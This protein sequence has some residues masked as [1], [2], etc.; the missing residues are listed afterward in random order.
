[1]AVK[2]TTCEFTGPGACSLCLVSE[3][4]SSP[5]SITTCMNIATV[6]LLLTPS[7]PGLYHALFNIPNSAVTCA[8]ACKVYTDLKFGSYSD[9]RVES[10]KSPLAFLPVR[11]TCT[12]AVSS[13]LPESST[14]AGTEKLTF[15]GVY[16]SR[17]VIWEPYSHNAFPVRDV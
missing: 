3:P 4:G 1:M 7:V 13:P 14:S 5:R 9:C 16:P 10:I 12:S 11:R 6:V 8:V 17:D 15:G 2:S